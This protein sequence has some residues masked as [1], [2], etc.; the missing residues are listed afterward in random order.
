MWDSFCFLFCKNMESKKIR[1]R[2]LVF[3][4]IPSY[5]NLYR[6]I[7]KQALQSMYN[8]LLLLCLV[9]LMGRLS[10]CWRIKLRGKCSGKSRSISHLREFYHLPDYFKFHNGYKPLQ[11]KRP[12][13]L[14]L[15][16][17]T[18]VPWH[19]FQICTLLKISLITQ[20]WNIVKRM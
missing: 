4:T 2:I 8:N 7:I 5:R 15:Y 13:H 17:G 20:E 1:I 9:H 12:C 11:L 18:N 14:R 10:F 3:H 16:R 19:M 6:H